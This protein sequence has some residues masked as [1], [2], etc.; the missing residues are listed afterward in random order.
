MVKRIAGLTAATLVAVAM[1]GLLGMQLV[2]TVETTLKKKAEQE[3]GPAPPLYS[4]ATNLR[5]LSPIV[6]NLG[7][8]EG[9]WV[10]LE[11]SIVFDEETIASPDVVAGEIAEDILAYLRTVSLPQIQGASGLL[12]LREDLNDR[13]AIRTQN[14]VRELII[15]TLVVQ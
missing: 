11:A 8:P 4:E 2:A 15:E 7:S 12:H 3:E 14:R 13:V 10:R 1:G 6:T 9:V 5:K